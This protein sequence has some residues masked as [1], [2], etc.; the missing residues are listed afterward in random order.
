[1]SACSR[2]SLRSFDW[3]DHLCDRLCI[4]PL[5]P[6]ALSGVHVVTAASHQEACHGKEASKL[7]DRKETKNVLSFVC[8]CVCDV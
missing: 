4:D 5:A 7:K 1:M 2:C 8:V 6:S 3:P